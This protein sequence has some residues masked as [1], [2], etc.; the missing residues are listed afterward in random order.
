MA[1]TTTQPA[2]AGAGAP[3]EA[4]SGMSVADLLPKHLEHLDA[5]I[6]KQKA[7]NAQLGAL[8][9]MAMG[10]VNERVD[11]AVRQSLTC[12]VFQVLAQ[13]WAKARELHDYADPAKHP[14]DETSTMFLGEHALATDLHPTVDV[15]LTGLATFEL[16][17]TLELQAV[18]RLAELTIRGGHIVELGKCDAELKVMLMYAGVPL[19]EPLKSRRVTLSN[20]MTFAAP[21]IPIA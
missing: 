5:Q 20:A 12:D 11:A 9:A 6:E 14:A 16:V 3:A 1:D 21:G 17:F 7:T 15:I 2:A 19:H 10:V 8:P 4:V 13:A 18:L